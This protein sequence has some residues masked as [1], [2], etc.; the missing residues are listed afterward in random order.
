MQRS[1][2]TATQQFLCFLQMTGQSS[3]WQKHLYSGTPA[4]CDKKIPDTVIKRTFGSKKASPFAEHRE[5]KIPDT[6]IKRTFVSKKTSPFAEHRE[7]KIPDTVIKRTFVSKK[8]SPF[9]ELREQKTSGT[10]IKCRYVSKK[11]YPFAEL[12]EEDLE[13]NF[14]RGSGPGGQSVN[15]TANCVVLKHK[16]SGIVVK[17]CMCH[18]VTVA[19]YFTLTSHAM[20]L[21]LN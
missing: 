11:T 1:V 20:V 4:F 3:A 19:G 9:A 8:T 12:R 2:F 16:P 7:Q 14:V 18:K 6:V 13:E 17:V 21:T 5:Q 10:V 15:Q